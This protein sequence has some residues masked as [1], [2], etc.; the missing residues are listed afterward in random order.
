[1]WKIVE[2]LITKILVAVPIASPSD[3][4]TKFISNTLYVTSKVIETIG[5]L[6]INRI[7]GGINSFGWS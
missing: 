1:M 2:S 5:I 7:R 4:D 6:P 3:L